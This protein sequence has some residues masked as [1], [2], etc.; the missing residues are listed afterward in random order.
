MKTILAW[1]IITTFCQCC[2]TGSRSSIRCLFGPRIRNRFYPDLRSWIPDPKSKFLKA[3]WQFVLY[4]VLLFFI[5]WLKFF[6]WPLNNGQFCDICGYK[7]LG[8]QNFPSLLFCC[9][10]W[11]LYPGWIKIKIWDPDKSRIC[12][13]AIYPTNITAFSKI[14]FHVGHGNGSSL[15]VKLKTRRG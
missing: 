14:C 3:L 8:Q 11:I 4:K 7:K 2:G 13:T 10:F 9:C 15:S 1:T 6:S 12:N 5:N